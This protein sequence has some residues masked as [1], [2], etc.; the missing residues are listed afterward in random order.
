MQSFV[1]TELSRTGRKH[2]AE[3]VVR[4]VALLRNAGIQNINIDLIAGLPGQTAAGWRQSLEAVSRL[5]VPH[6]SVYMLEVDDDSRLG[7]EIRLG[8]KRYGAP[9]VPEDDQI[10][11]FYEEAVE[12]LAQ[13]GMP[14]YEISNFARPGLESLHNLKYWTREPYIGFGADA[15][16]F[17]GVSRW[18][19]AESA[20]DYVARGF[21]GEPLRTET[22][23]A[24]PDEEKFYV[25]LRLAQGVVTETADWK[26]HGS[27]FQ[28]FLAT[29]M[30]ERSGDRL[31]LTNRG[32][33]VS[34]EIFEEFLTA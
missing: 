4:D 17:D 31:R 23:A 9:D 10:A 19:N 11:A 18:Q 6:V 26:R 30:M 1:K 15:H 3:T 33:M 16:S 14:R 2:D 22:T 12:F 29:G 5:E 28:R 21:R 8:G 32:V 27:A 34:N 7:S 25:G 20:S 13:E 24:R